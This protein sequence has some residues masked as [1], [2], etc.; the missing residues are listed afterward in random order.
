MNH[1]SEAA[2]LN[3][4]IMTSYRVFTYLHNPDIQ[5]ASLM[6]HRPYAVLI[7]HMFS[8]E[9]K[10]IS[11]NLGANGSVL[12][13]MVFYLSYSTVSS[14]RD[15]TSASHRTVGPAPWVGQHDSDFHSYDFRWLNQVR[16][17]SSSLKKAVEM[18]LLWVIISVMTSVLITLSRWPGAAENISY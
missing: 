10:W 14:P 1:V 3:H 9:L 7:R 5:W 16:G 2:W 11:Y 18:E 15:P 17:H 6:W 4:R 13:L 8:L 12:L